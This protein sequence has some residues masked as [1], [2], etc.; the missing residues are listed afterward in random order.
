MIYFIQQVLI[1]TAAMTAL[2]LI[3][4]G[5]R[6]LLEQKQS[7]CW[8]YAVWWILGI[9]FLTPLK[10]QFGHGVVEIGNAAPRGIPIGY[11]GS[12]H[13][14]SQ[15]WR[16]VLLIWLIGAVISAYRMIMHQ[17]HFSR[18]VKRLSRPADEV[19]QTVYQLICMEMEIPADAE[20]CVLPVINTPML[21][22]IVHPRIL[23]PD[24]AYSNE[25]LRMIFKHELTHYMRGDLFCKLLWM[26]CSVLHWF[27]PLL[28]KFL[29]QM[30]QDCE[31]A[32]DEEVL[33]GESEETAAVYCSTILD[34]AMRRCRAKSQNI[35]LA[36]NFSGS[37]ENLRSRIH[38]ILFRHK[39]RRF[40]TVFLGT[41]LLTLL[42]GSLIAYADN[43]YSAGERAVVTEILTDTVPVQST[44]VYESEFGYTITDEYGQPIEEVT[45]PSERTVTYYDEATATTVIESVII[46]YGYVYETPDAE[47][48]PEVGSTE[49]PP[50][51]PPPSPPSPPESPASPIP[52]ESPVTVWGD[53][54][55]P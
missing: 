21:T 17:Y 38:A 13:H 12:V 32:C 33:R 42:T 19:A 41:A 6:R 48:V 37:K 10:P 25:E 47:S 44:A 28:P 14:T 11:I 50:D 29:R 54:I 5:I 20:V 51:F 8:R 22:G 52:P 23:L 27:N 53:A 24:T 4:F 1:C 45:A 34:T 7:A 2:T 39:R 16:L 43:T 46:D 40:L 18:S 49:L 3:F 26:G 36:T 55:H 35:V 9:G 15:F 30:E 31:M